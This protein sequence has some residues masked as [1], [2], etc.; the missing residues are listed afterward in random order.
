MEKIVELWKR[1]GWRIM[2]MHLA[3]TIL[4]NTRNAE[5]RDHGLSRGLCPKCGIRPPAKG[6]ANCGTCRKNAQRDA[7]RRRAERLEAGLC[8][9]CAKRKERHNEALL[10]CDECLAKA[11]AQNA[12]RRRYYARADTNQRKG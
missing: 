4:E 12:E 2:P 11:R 3:R 6:Y 5:R 7:D 10:H 9:R 1:H 8:L